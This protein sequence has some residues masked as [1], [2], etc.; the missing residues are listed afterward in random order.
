M[1][2]KKVKPFPWNL[3]AML[4]MLSACFS[5]GKIKT[6]WP[7]TD[8]GTF[9][10]CNPDDVRLTSDEPAQRQIGGTWLQ[11]TQQGAIS[12]SSILEFKTIAPNKYKFQMSSISRLTI[13]S[14]LQKLVQET[15]TKSSGEAIVAGN[16]ILLNI[17]ENQIQA[18]SAKTE[19][20]M[21]NERFTEDT[22]VKL[23]SGRS[24]MAVLGEANQIATVAS[25]DITNTKSPGPTEWNGSTKIDTVFTTDLGAYK[26]QLETVVHFDS[27]PDA[28]AKTIMT[29]EG[30]ADVGV[31]FRATEE[32]VVAKRP[33]H[34]GNVFSASVFQVHPAQNEVVIYHPT[35]LRKLN[36]GQ[37]L[38]IKSRRSGAQVA[39]VKVLRLNYT[40]AIAVVESGTIQSI[41]VADLALGY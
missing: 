9:P 1:P 20:E 36:V 8:Y 37:K 22:V 29:I 2:C 28:N 16:E 19:E 23:Q 13:D 31:F 15:I 24:K 27:R 34:S 32:T 25:C 5:T 3:T 6:S 30:P 11:K 12:G 17:K 38:D 41:D 35:N 10:F 26:T 40:N 39:T 21:D 14:T 7:S 4:L 18:K 33:R